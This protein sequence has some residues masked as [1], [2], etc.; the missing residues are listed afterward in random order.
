[1]SNADAFEVLLIK[2]CFQLCW[3]ANIFID[4]NK[5]LLQLLVDEVYAKGKTF[6]GLSHI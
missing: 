6:E 3:V 4:C 2:K 5:F 1:M